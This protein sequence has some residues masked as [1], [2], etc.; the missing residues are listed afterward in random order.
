MD[1]ALK[2]SLNKSDRLVECWAKGRELE[3]RGVQGAGCGAPE[4]QSIEI[5]KTVCKQDAGKLSINY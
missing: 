1:G 3:S 5:D 4:V 2:S